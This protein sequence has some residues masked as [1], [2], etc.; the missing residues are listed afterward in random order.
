[1]RSRAPARVPPR[2]CWRTPLWLFDRLNAEFRF[3]LDAAASPDDALCDRY[4]T[5]ALG[6]DPWPG[7]RIWVNPPYSRDRLVPILDRAVLEADLGKTVVALLPV[8]TEM[9][10]WHDQVLATATEVRFIRGRI[11]FVPPPGIEPRPGGSRPVF[12][13]AVV[14]YRRRWPRRNTLIVG[15]MDG[16]PPGRWLPAGERE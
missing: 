11:K 14:I 2:D 8:R 5:N 9:P 15:S 4:L 6:P 3:D 12:S 16:R 1:M 10:W 13:S 7:R